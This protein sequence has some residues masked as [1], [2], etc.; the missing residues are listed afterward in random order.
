MAAVESDPERDAFRRSRA[1]GRL[2]YPD[3]ALSRAESSGFADPRKGVQE[4]PSKDPDPVYRDTFS[5]TKAKHC[6]RASRCIF[7]LIFRIHSYLA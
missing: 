4:E 3:R 6:D 5:A 1:A 7:Q 2:S